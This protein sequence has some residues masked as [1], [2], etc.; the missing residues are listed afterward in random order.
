VSLW[1]AV[2]SPLAVLALCDV[3]AGALWTSAALCASICHESLSG[4]ARRG[5]TIS[6]TQHTVKL[7]AGEIRCLECSAEWRPEETTQWRG[8]LTGEWPPALALYC[9]DCAKREF[10]D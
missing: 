4:I 5:D 3:A 1:A 9:P 2:E 8:Y 10:D 7:A 6:V